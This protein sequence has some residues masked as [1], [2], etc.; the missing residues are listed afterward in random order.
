MLEDKKLLIGSS[1][2]H[3]SNQPARLNKNAKYHYNEAF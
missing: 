1:L 2:I 3:S